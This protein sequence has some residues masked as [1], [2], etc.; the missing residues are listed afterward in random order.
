MQEG[1]SAGVMLVGKPRHGPGIQTSYWIA[2][3]HSRGPYLSPTW[4]LAKIK[5]N[6]VL[7]AESA[8]HQTLKIFPPPAL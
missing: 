6:S 5:I 2:F 7:C 4:F 8:D 3:H 1:P